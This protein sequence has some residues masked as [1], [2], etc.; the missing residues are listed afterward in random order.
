MQGPSL[1]SDSGI[2]TTMVGERTFATE[3]FKIGADGQVALTVESGAGTKKVKSEVRIELKNGKVEKMVAVSGPLKGGLV[4]IP[5]GYKYSRLDSTP[6]TIPAPDGAYLVSPIAPSLLQF[7][8][9]AYDTAKAGPQKFPVLVLDNMAIGEALV[10]R[11]SNEIVETAAGKLITD[12]YQLTSASFNVEWFSIG[13]RAIRAK[14][15]GG[16]A[17]A[18]RNGFEAPMTLK[19]FKLMPNADKYTSVQIVVTSYKTN[20]AGSATHPHGAGKTP[21]FLFLTGMGPQ[22]RDNNLF[23]ASKSYLFAY[24][25]DDLTASGNSTF[26]FDDRGVASSEGSSADATIKTMRLDYQNQLD[27]LFQSG[28]VEPAKVFLIAQGEGAIIAQ[29]LC[30][31]NKRIAGL[32]LLGAPGETL[33][34]TMLQSYALRAANKDLAQTA[35]DEAKAAKAKLESAIKQAKA[36]ATGIAEG[37]NLDWLREHLALRLPEVA[38]YV[39]CPV[40]IVQGGSDDTLDPKQADKLR[41]LLEGAG[42]K[43][44]KVATLPKTTH[45]FGHYPVNNPAYDAK[46]PDKINPALFDTVRSWVAG[47]L[48]TA[49]NSGK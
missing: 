8:Q 44:V 7:L 25:A 47:V 45:N 39:K 21:A 33:D 6:T 30:R 1:P 46:E 16:N 28:F 49:D 43:A 27:L 10:E 23:P 31:E 37:M 40:L 24:L 19:P 41:K 42:N 36:G 15:A 20:L 5:E 26:R 4:R 22:D 17:V 11:K 29:L 38:K 35:R 3:E 32:I 2:F 9:N 18:Y 12:H 34:K 14:T 13:Q 48:K